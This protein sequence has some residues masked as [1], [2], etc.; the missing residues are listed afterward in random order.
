MRRTLGETLRQTAGPEPSSSELTARYQKQ[1]ADILVEL[2]KI[3]ARI[4]RLKE[5][6]RTAP[7]AR[8]RA[9]KKQMISQLRQQKALENRYQLVEAELFNID[10]LSFQAPAEP[11]PGPSAL[12]SVTVEG[13]ADEFDGDALA[14]E[15]NAIV[16]LLRADG[17]A[18]LDEREFAREVKELDA[19]GAARIVPFDGILPEFDEVVSEALGD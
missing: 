4:E 18:A 15:L 3:A 19:R 12:A 14:P 1:K 17:K 11:P 9:I 16:D 10:Q 6:L 2:E 8:E 13:A 7:Q 5:S